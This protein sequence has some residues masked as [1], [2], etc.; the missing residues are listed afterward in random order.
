MRN[1]LSVEIFS[2]GTTPIVDAG[3]DFRKFE[4]MQFSTGYPGGL[5]LSG[6]LYVPRNV[7]KAWL[8]KGAQ[9]LRILNG[10]TVV[11]EGQIASLDRALTQDTQMVLI[12]VTGHWGSLLAS[13]RLQR[14]YADMRTSADVWV[15]A[16]PRDVHVDQT[17]Y[18]RYD[19]D[20]GDAILRATPQSGVTWGSNDRTTLAF[21]A[22][23]GEEIRRMDFDADFDEAG[24]DWRIRIRDRTNNAHLYTRTA[25]GTDTGQNVE[26]ASGCQ[27]IDFHLTNLSGSTIPSSGAGVF[28]ELSNVVVY[29]TMN[30]TPSGGKDTVDLTE[31]TKDLRAELSEL[32][33]DED[34]IASNTLSLMPFVAPRFPTMADILSRASQ[35]GDASG[36]RWAVGVKGSHLS[37]DAKPVIFAEQFPDLTTGAFEYAVRI[38]EP[39]LVP[40][41]QI[42]SGFI[43]SDENRVWNYIIIE[44]AD[45]RGFTFFQTPEDDATLKDQD[46][47]DKYGRRDFRLSIGHGTTTL[48]SSVGARFLATHK[49]PPWNLKGPISVKNS[50][51]GDQGQ[52]IPV[53]QIQAGKRLKLENFVIDP[54]TD[55][56]DLIFL[57]TKTDY[58]DDEQV[59]SLTVGVP[60]S[61]DVYLAQRELV[62]EQLLR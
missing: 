49:D 28:G 21:Y 42:T 26:P 9:R 25:T 50:I 29:A 15:N 2:S 3:D 61:L 10:V 48:A 47:I 44:Y 59:N 27:R 7:V 6:I 34:F 56:L 39:N 41:F 60:N 52:P 53:S 30:H 38:D 20:S 24:Q 16:T 12:N 40:P 36:N 22:P 54:A 23:P 35:Y 5:S 32:S 11:F 18:S 31:I 58:I 57:I 1:D 37:S 46:S 13:R 45:E 55:L 14:L 19:A 62:D 17:Q 51:R 43:G 33:A 8:I 4:Q